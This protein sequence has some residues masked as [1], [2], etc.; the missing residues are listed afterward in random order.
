MSL[1]NKLSEERRA[2]LAAERLLEQKKAELQAA[3]RKLGQHAQALNDEIVE[4][5]AQVE[6]FRHENAR[7]KSD[8]HAANVKVEQL[9]RR[10]W[11]SIETIQDGIAFFNSDSRLIAANA[12]WIS[13]FDGLEAIKPGL[14]YVEMLQFATEEGIVD[15]GEMHP[16]EWREAMLDRWQS[17]TPEPEIIRLWNGAYIKVIDQRGY[18]GDVVSLAMNITDTVRYE[19]RLKEARAK[20]ETAARAKAAFLANMSHEIR[21]PMNGVVGMAELLQDTDLTDEQQLYAE[22]I[23]NSGDALL[24]IIN[25]VLDYSKIEAQKLVLHEDEFDLERTIHE[26]IMLMQP[27]ARDKRIELLVDY[28]MFLPTLFV[29]DRGRIRQVITNLMGNAV[30]FTEQGS[31][32]VRVVGMSREEEGHATLHVTVED[33]GIGIPK[34]KVE[35]IFGEFNQVDDEHNRKY[36]GTGLG[37]A[38]SQKL[39]RLMKGE[40]WVTSEEGHGSCFGFSLRLPVAEEL[41]ADAFR[42]PPPLRSAV[43]VEP[44]EASRMIVQRQLG[45]MGIETVCFT[46]AGDALAALPDDAGVVITDHNMHDMDGM[47]LAQALRE[48]GHQV[49]I[50]LLTTTIGAAEQDPARRYMHTVL[51]KPYPRQAFFRALS[52]LQQDW[53]E[54]AP[55]VPQVDAPRAMRVLAAE[56]NKT[57]RLVFSKMLKSLDIELEFAENGREAV[58]LFDS[59]APDIV[60]TDISM[61]EVDGKEATRKIREREAGTGAH[62]PVIA[63]TAHAMDGDDAEILAAGIDYYLTK[64]LRRKAVIE[65][66]LGACRDGMR[67]PLGEDQ[68][69]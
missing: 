47:E 16:A 58:E 61:P 34:E 8:L 52:S 11:H 18:G 30:K 65:H 28:D 2:R 55:P 45:A 36:E 14:S 54:A 13:I 63:M 51:Q 9:E 3:N 6:T 33:T 15:I 39:I 44:H 41:T 57:N 32:T 69:D 66:I 49:P 10:L 42:L 67:P 17:A 53:K 20:A 7:V 1:A 64:P 50:I 24:V 48:A 60:F 56:D 5:R 31:V 43:I 46:S 22:T 62:V 25:D 23:K 4:T 21:T 40:I 59:F 12:A 35:H 27:N 38:I 26:I 29:G 19:L 68:A 37:L